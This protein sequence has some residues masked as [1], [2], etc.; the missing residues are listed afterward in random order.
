MHAVWA[1]VADG[2]MPN[3]LARDYA[4]LRDPCVYARCVWVAASC[5]CDRSLAASRCLKRLHKPVGLLVIVL[6]RKQSDSF[7][8]NFSF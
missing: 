7:F 5:S 4:H 1:I 2:Y 3:R 6:E 8:S